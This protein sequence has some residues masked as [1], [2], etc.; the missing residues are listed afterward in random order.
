MKMEQKI[1]ENYKKVIKI[2]T[3]LIFLSG[4]WVRHGLIGRLESRLCKE[5]EVVIR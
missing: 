4:V 3:F 5:A 1:D 2:K